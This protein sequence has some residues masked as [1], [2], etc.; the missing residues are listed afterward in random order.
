MVFGA[1]SRLVPTNE[2]ISD[3]HFYGQY[4]GAGA[5]NSSYGRIVNNGH[6]GAL[7]MTASDNNSPMDDTVTSEQ[8]NVLQ[9]ANN[10]EQ[11]KN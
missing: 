10:I 1:D 7:G 5:T 11:G 2:N 6:K 9:A 4:Q 8:A 3:L